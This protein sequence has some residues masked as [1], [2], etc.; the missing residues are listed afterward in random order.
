MFLATVEE[1]VGPTY[2]WSIFV[3]NWLESFV[4]EPV[5][6]TNWSHADVLFQSIPLKIN[7]KDSSLIAR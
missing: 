7:D 5:H 6:G 2:S 1:F 3:L 4:L